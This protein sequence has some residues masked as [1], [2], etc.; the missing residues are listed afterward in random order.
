MR[1]IVTGSRDWEGVGAEHKIQTILNVVL[2]LAEVLGHKLTIVHGGCPTGAD[3]A[4]DRWARRRDDTGV[5]V[6]VHAA[7][8]GAFGKA[9]GPLR[10]RHMTEQGADMCIAFIRGNSRGATGTVQLAM[11]NQIP[12]FVVRWEEPE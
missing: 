6:E 2:A 8:W 9:A 12:T 7:N 3:Q 11:N 1:V 5:A 4:I 10:N